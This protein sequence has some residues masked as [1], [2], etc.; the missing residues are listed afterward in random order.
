M[1]KDGPAMPFQLFGIVKRKWHVG[2]G[3]C[4]CFE[5]LRQPL[6]SSFRPWDTIGRRKEYNIVF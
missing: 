2:H 5:L 3:G 4:G 6:P 1:Y